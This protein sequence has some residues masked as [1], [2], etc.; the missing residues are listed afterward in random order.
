[1][2]LGVA[3]LLLAVVNRTSA[4]AHHLYLAV[5]R[6]TIAEIQHRFSLSNPALLSTAGK[7]TFY[8]QGQLPNLGVKLFEVD[9]WSSR[10]RYGKHISCPLQQVS[11]ALMHFTPLGN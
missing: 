1:M 11:K 10:F 8:L 3:W 9:L 5:D 7:K 4:D 2:H 6:Q